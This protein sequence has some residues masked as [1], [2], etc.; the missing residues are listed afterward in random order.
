MP[1]GSARG[2]GGQV[3]GR[4]ER[5]IHV[6]K[7]GVY[8]QPEHDSGKTDGDHRVRGAHRFGGCSGVR[9][10]TWRVLLD[11]EV[12]SFDDRGPGRPDRTGYLGLR[13]LRSNS[14]P[15][16]RR[17]GAH[18]RATT[19]GVTRRRVKSGKAPR[20]SWHL[21]QR[22]QLGI[23]KLQILY[24][25]AREEIRARD[26]APVRPPERPPRSRS[27]RH[28]RDTLAPSGSA[29]SWIVRPDGRDS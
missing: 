27:L 6:L 12:C 23:C 14:R 11:A 17:W 19:F 10:A 16:A 5:G 8:P 3:R 20:Q 9:S 4:Y 25:L 7:T 18:W 13:R 29:Q 24:T 15:G 22:W 26:R 2:K 28:R 21:R 1:S